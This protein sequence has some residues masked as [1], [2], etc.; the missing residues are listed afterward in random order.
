MKK[1]ISNIFRFFI[2]LFLAVIFASCSFLNDSTKENDSSQLITEDLPDSKA[3]FTFTGTISISEGA[4]PSS[5]VNKSKASNSTRAAWPEIPSNLTYSVTAIADGDETTKIEGT[6]TDNTS[7]Q[8]VLTSGKEWTV[9]AVLNDVSG[10]PVLSDS[11]TIPA[12]NKETNLFH[13]AANIRTFSYICR[14]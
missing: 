12:N 7:F 5:F 10:N 11:W 13:L 1:H 9:T 4:F 2:V 8:F 3:T 14:N 6:K